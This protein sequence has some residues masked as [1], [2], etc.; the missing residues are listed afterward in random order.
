[1]WSY[2]HIHVYNWNIKTIHLSWVPFWRFVLFWEPITDQNE[3]KLVKFDVKVCVKINPGN[4]LQKLDIKSICV[5]QNRM[6]DPKAINYKFILK[7]HK[8]PTWTLSGWIERLRLCR[9]VCVWKRSVH[10]ATLQIIKGVYLPTFLLKGNVNVHI[11]IQDS[12]ID[13]LARVQKTTIR[14]TIP[15]DEGEIDRR[16]NI[17]L[18][19]NDMALIFVF[20]LSFQQEIFISV[21]ETVCHS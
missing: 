7:P 3:G 17:L 21:V 16:Y 8:G 20:C 11:R 12:N 4:Y 1:M 9:E 15:T 13:L 6:F 14:V 19:R 18:S 5:L 2:W 10:K